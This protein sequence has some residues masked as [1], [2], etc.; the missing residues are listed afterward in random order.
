MWR[1]TARLLVS[2]S[3]LI[4]AA[5]LVLVWRQDGYPILL[6]KR[7]RL[8]L[9]SVPWTETPGP[10]DVFEQGWPT[11]GSFNAKALGIYYVRVSDGTQTHWNLWFEGWT[12]AIPAAIAPAVWLISF[13]RALRRKRA[14]GLAGC[15]PACGYDLRA[16]PDRCPECG[17]LPT[18]QA[19]S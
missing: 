1:W 11:T 5:S 12:P 3:L 4:L 18:R 13:V 14:A 8:H 15:C 19:A 6:A 2:L 9:W 10:P 17:Y 16:T 7:D